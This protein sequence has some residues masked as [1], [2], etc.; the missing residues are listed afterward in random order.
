MNRGASGKIL[1]CGNTYEKIN[2]ARTRYEESVMLPSFNKPRLK[3]IKDLII[4]FHATE[5]Y[6]VNKN[7]IFS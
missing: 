5:Q 1:A 3:Q 4:Q 6:F 2:T 7:P